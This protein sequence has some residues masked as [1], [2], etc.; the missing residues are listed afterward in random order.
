MKAAVDD[1]GTGWVSVSLALEPAEVEV[2]VR[3]LEELRSGEV[4]HFHLRTD[5]FSPDV[6]VADVEFSLMGSG[7]R[8]NMRIE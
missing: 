5:D 7:E 3:R 4:A 2:L 8:D 1:P 6:G